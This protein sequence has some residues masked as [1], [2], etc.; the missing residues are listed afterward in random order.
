MKQ[1]RLLKIYS[2]SKKNYFSKLNKDKCYAVEYD[3]KVSTIDILKR[4]IDLFLTNNHQKR[5]YH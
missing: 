2:M 3:K 4:K 5:K 1:K